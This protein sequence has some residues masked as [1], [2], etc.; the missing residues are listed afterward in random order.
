MI[1][2]IKS[3]IT[4][5]VV[6]VIALLLGIGI[7]FGTCYF[8]IK[9]TV[10][11]EVKIGG[12]V[13]NKANTE[14]ALDKNQKSGDS[15]ETARRNIDH[16]YNNLKQEAVNETPD[17]ADNYV[18]P[19]E[20]LRRWRAANRGSDSSTAS[21]KPDAGA[22]ATATA[23]GREHTDAGGEPHG[24]GEDVPPTGSADVRAAAPDRD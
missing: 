17:S 19:D 4:L 10:Q 1:T 22:A 2:T 6:A 14:K 15:H 12:H 3:N 5:I 21:S 24:S 20:R 11:T 7:G 13:Q 18:L 16:F 8:T 23:S 9:H